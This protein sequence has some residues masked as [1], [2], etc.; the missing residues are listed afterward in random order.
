MKI[1]GLWTL[2]LELIFWAVRLF[3]RAG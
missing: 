3:L 1:V 2:L